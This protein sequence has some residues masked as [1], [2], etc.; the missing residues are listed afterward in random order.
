M[1][2]CNRL[3]QKYAGKVG[4]LVGVLGREITACASLGTSALHLGMPLH[5]VGKAPRHNFTLGHNF[6]CSGTASRILG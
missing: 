4:K 6:M 5:V 3:L 1:P 2:H